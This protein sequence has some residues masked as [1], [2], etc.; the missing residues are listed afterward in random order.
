MWLPLALSAVVVAYNNLV[1]QSGQFQSWAYVPTNLAFA[2]IVSGVTVLLG[3]AWRASIAPVGTL[4]P[5]VVVAV[6]AFALVI[7]GIARSSHAHRIADER[8]AGLRGGALAYYTL[9]RIPFG[10]A[11]TEELLFRGVLFALWLNAGVSV[12]G[13][14]VASS[15]AFGMWHVAP[16]MIALRI[17]DPAVW[18]QKVWTAVIGAVL[19]TT[20]AGLGLTWLRVETGGLL[21]PIMLHAAINSVGAVGALIASRHP[22][23]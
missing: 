7:F 23:S 3:T 15:I 8:V 1:N 4:H 5:F 12:A 11:V 21:A 6:V 2:G 17:N 9:I 19:L 16:T 14:A 20:V 10:T 22:A 18:K 13:A